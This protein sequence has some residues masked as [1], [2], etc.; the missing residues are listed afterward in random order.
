M[1]E[2]RRSC[3]P[4][5]AEQQAYETIRQVWW[6]HQDHLHKLNISETQWEQNN[7]QTKQS[8]KKSACFSASIWAELQTERQTVQLQTGGTWAHPGHCNLILCVQQNHHWRWQ[9]KMKQPQHDEVRKGQLYWNKKGNNSSCCKVLN[10]TLHSTVLLHPH[11]AD[12]PSSWRGGVRGIYP[13]TSPPTSLSRLRNWFGMLSVSWWAS[14]R[15]R[16][17]SVPECATFSIR[18]SQS[19]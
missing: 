6:N 1:G 15:K 10:L 8:K 3:S 14:H 5:E 7:K 2:L 12:M 9:E 13:P 17:K 11:T 16:G 4:P 18:F 19:G